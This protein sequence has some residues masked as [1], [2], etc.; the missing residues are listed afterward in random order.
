MAGYVGLTTP[1]NGVGPF[2]VQIVDLRTTD[3]DLLIDWNTVPDATTY[4]VY[5][6]GFAGGPMP[7]NDRIPHP[8][9]Q[10]SVTV[11]RQA[12]DWDLPVRV[13]PE[14]SAGSGPRTI[15]VITIPKR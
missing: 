14:N 9:S 10:H 3:A 8:T 12:S 1:V 11:P 2:T 7:F 13:T 5:A 15:Q 4:H 6:P